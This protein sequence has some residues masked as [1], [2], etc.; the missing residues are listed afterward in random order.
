MI[1]SK[2]YHF[3]EEFYPR[4][5]R[6]IPYA[7]PFMCLLSL[8][9]GQGVSIDTHTASVGLTVAT[10]VAVLGTLGIW[11]FGFGLIILTHDSG[12]GANIGLALL[13]MLGPLAVSALVPIAYHLAKRLASSQR[14]SHS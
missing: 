12:A 10:A 9:P 14:Q 7:L 3:E 1:T 11:L 13:L 2:S 5:M 4:V 6:T 8:I